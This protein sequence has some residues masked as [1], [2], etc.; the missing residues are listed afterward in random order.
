MSSFIATPTL[1]PSATDNELIRN[2]G[3]F[4]DISLTELRATMRIDGT[5][6]HERLREATLDAIDSVNNE[7]HAWRALQIAAGHST[8]A[9]IPTACIDGQ[10]VQIIRYR[11]AVFNLAHADI[12]ERYRDWDTTKSGGQKAEDLEQT[13]C[14]ARRNVRWALSDLRGLSRT[15]VELI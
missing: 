2:D 13:I 4:P 7:L 1:D 8:L 15:T 3:F 5:V 6:T 14:N 10:S 12:T 11:R 9:D